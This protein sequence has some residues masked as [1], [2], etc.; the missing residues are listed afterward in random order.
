[1]NYSICYSE[2]IYT[3]A[4]PQETQGTNVERLVAWLLDH[5]NLEVPDLDSTPKDTP[6]PAVT[7]ETDEV[8]ERR[9]AVMVYESSSD[10]SSSSDVGE[11]DTEGESIYTS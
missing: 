3:P 1:M 6:P 7:T 9:D 2:Y 8:T 10:S 5:I 4:C 11:S